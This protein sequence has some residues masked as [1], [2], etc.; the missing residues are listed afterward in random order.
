[1]VSDAKERV[2]VDTRSVDS[3]DSAA[4]VEP[5][6]GQDAAATP[7]SAKAAAAPPAVEDGRTAGPALRVRPYVDMATSTITT[8]ATTSAVGAIVSEVS[9][10]NSAIGALATCAQACLEKDADV[11]LPFSESTFVAFCDTNLTT[12]YSTASASQSTASS[13]TTTTSS[14]ISTTPTKSSLPF[15]ILEL[16]AI[17]LGALA[18]LALR[19]ASE[20]VAARKAGHLYAFYVKKTKLGVSRLAVF[21][22]AAFLVVASLAVTVAL[23][24]KFGFSGP[25][26]A[27]AI[28]SSV[29]TITALVLLRPGTHVVGAASLPTATAAGQAHTIG[30]GGPGTSPATDGPDSTAV[31]EP[32][33]WLVSPGGPADVTPLPLA[34]EEYVAP[35]VDK[36]LRSGATKPAAAAFNVSKHVGELTPKALESGFNPAPGHVGVLIYMSLAATATVAAA[37]ASAGS[38]V[39]TQTSKTA[40][41]LAFCSATG[42][43]CTAFTSQIVQNELSSILSQT[44]GQ[45]C[46]TTWSESS[47]HALSSTLEQCEQIPSDEAAQIETCLSSYL[48]DISYLGSVC[49]LTGDFGNILDEASAICTP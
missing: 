29:L 25:S 48:Q 7:A 28:A 49:A 19:V 10:I 26:Q 4:S 27:L 38:T 32:S 6:L 24:I 5:L 33:A 15:P 3:R 1:Q 44:A 41:A 42:D 8:T 14:Q 36:A 2:S 9:H 35:V 39:T 12:Y 37:A 46:W 47:S 45:T 43:C 16:V 20:L 18:V 40:T 11:S 21:G 13:A 30:D 22:T 31:T 23:F 34:T 17:I